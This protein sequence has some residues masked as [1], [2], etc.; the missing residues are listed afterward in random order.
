MKKY[1][2]LTT[3]FILNLQSLVLA[4]AQGAQESPGFGQMLFPL[5]ATVAIIYFLVLRPQ[6]R[7]EKSFQE[8]VKKIE[9]GD[10]VTTKGGLI[11]RVTNIADKILT[12]EVA[13]KTR[14]KIDRNFVQEVT[15]DK[16]AATA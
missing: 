15:K 16:P 11:G 1:L 12:I 6:V 4:Q 10:E 13:E 7:R 3:A 14:V 9:K 2:I 5:V 8:M